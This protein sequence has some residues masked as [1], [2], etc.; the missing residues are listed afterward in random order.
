MNLK[1]QI[2]EILNSTLSVEEKRI[3]LLGRKGLLSLQFGTLKNLPKNKIGAYGKE[4]NDLKTYVENFLT[5]KTETS[6]QIFDLSVPASEQLIAS[7][8]PISHTIDEMVDIFS[9]LGFDVFTGPEIVSDFDNFG[10]LNFSE[11]HPARDTQD[12]FMI[13]NSA[14]MMRTQTSAMQVEVMK[15]NELPVRAIV[16]GKTYRREADATHAPMFNQ[17]EGFVVDNK[18][19][20][21]DLKGILTNFVELYF[22]RKIPMRFRPHYFPFTEPSAE[23]DILWKQEGKEDRWLEI[24]GCGCIHPNVLTTAGINPKIYQGIAFGLGIE[25]PFMLK[26]GVNDMRDIYKN[27]I[28]FLKQLAQL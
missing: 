14:K 5:K 20:F 6:E 21:A 13:K 22:G 12:S 7:K 16:P 4:L 28:S 18:V 25:R 8:H 15:N 24:L 19:S 26:H 27:E 11:D 2:E 10:S 17:L 1:K 9:T 3:K 23:I